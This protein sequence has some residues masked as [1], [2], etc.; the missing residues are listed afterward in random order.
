MPFY[1]DRNIRVTENPRKT[2]CPH[3]I[4]FIKDTCMYSFGCRTITEDAY[5]KYVRYCRDRGYVDYGKFNTFARS[6][7]YHIFHEQMV[8]NLTYFPVNYTAYKEGVGYVNK[9]G[10]AYAG[11]LINY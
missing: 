3:I 6:F 7:K 9:S 1:S 2:N 10:Y 4:E 5:D 11:L 8:N